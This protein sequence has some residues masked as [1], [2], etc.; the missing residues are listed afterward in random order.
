MKS[1]ESG[2]GKRV[3]AG[4]AKRVGEEPGQEFLVAA[5]GASAGGVEAFTDLMREVPPDTGMAFVLIQHLDPKHH[6]M[7]T[8]VIARETQMNV[9]EVT[10]GMELEPNHVFVIPPNTTMT[11]SDHV[12][13]LAPRSQGTGVH[14]PIDHFMRSLAEEQGPR[15]IGVILSG[16]GSDGTQGLAEIQGGGGVTFAQDES[17]ARHDG[18]PRIARAAPVCGQT[19]CVGN[20][21]HVQGQFEI[22]RDLPTAAQSHGTRFHTLPADDDLAAY[23]AADGRAQN[24]TSGRLRKVCADEPLGSESPVPGHAH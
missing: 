22:E 13:T 5:V 16:F 6:S 1:R 8:D 12:L 4:T 21:A 9:T 11:L 14:M 3:G 7:L 2:A 18:M 19:R 17:T 24:R 23:S 10:D 15:A 20:S